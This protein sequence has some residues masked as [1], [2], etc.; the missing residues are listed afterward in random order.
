MA[1]YTPNIPI[2]I[3]IM[4][5]IKL[6]ILSEEWKMGDR[7]PSVRDLSVDFLVNPNTM[8]RALGELERI[9]L[10]Y[11][12]RTSGRFITNDQ[13]KI[14]EIRKEK[15]EQSISEFLEKMQ[16]LGFSNEQIIKMIEGD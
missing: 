13:E 5:I 16:K 1:D 12:E 6:K 7:V 4:D 14:N 9:G 3:Q 2:Y 10:L 11:S 15:A 8:Q